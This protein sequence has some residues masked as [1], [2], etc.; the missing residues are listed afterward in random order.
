[1]YSQGLAQHL[2]KDIARKLS[3]QNLKRPAKSSRPCLNGLL[4]SPGPQPPALAPSPQPPAAIY[5]LWHFHGTACHRG[6]SSHINA[7]TTMPCQCCVQAAPQ[8]PRA[9]WEGSGGPP[10]PPRS[11]A[12][13]IQR[14]KATL[15]SDL[16]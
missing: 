11:T 3:F 6:T 7:A 4:G 13:L 16:D 15:M 10:P 5:T 9:P 2:R 12:S 1:M 8:A 14:P